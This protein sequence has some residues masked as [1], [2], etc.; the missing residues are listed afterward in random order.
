MS[1]KY[2]KSVLLP[3]G[4]EIRHKSAILEGNGKISKFAQKNNFH[5]LDSRTDHIAG[6]DTPKEAVEKAKKASTY[7]ELNWDT[8][9]KIEYMKN[10][11]SVKKHTSW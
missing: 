2:K 7:R 4:W 8:P 9:S 10:G 6:A 5:V 3:K 1:T 11:G